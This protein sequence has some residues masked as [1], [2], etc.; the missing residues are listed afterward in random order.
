METYSITEVCSHDIAEIK[1]ISTCVT[2]ETT[3]LVC[4]TC[5]EALE[6]PKTEC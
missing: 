5:G 6:P 2:C 3:Q 1:I 4:S